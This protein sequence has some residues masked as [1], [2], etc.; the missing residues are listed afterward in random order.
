MFCDSP[1]NLPRAVNAREAVATP[2]RSDEKRARFKY[3]QTGGSR[4]LTDFFVFFSWKNVQARILILA[5]S[6]YRRRWRV[7]RRRFRAKRLGRKFPSA[8]AAAAV[9]AA[10]VK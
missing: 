4:P 8:A 5:L 1:T 3:H 2:G 7:A 9:A 6:L 10:V